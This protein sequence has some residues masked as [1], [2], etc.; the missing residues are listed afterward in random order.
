FFTDTQWT[1]LF[2]DK[3][4][5]ILPL[6][7]ATILT[8]L[9]AM[10]ISISFGLTIAVYIS[11]Y[12]SPEKRMILKPILE[13]LATIPTVVYGY[14]ALLFITPLLRKIFPGISTFNALSP[15]IVM[16]FM[17]IPIIA[18]MSDDAMQAVPKWLRE[19][20]YALAAN[21]F[22]VTTGVVI[23]SALSGIMASFI[24]GISRAIGETMIVTI[25][26]GQMPNL[27]FNVMEPMETI[28]AY[29]VQVSLGDTPTG[30]IEFRTIFATGMTLF[31]L[32]FILNVISYFLKSKYRERYR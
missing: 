6:L 7:N 30:S 28:T 19:G 27:T 2:E 20:G 18:T 31:V 17:I 13:I 4:F 22:Q 12:L 23:P 8:S 11:E 25:A 1:P 10:I 5:G 14:F 21:K 9:I 3:H 15:G 16:G 24:L 32:T 26:A 29:I